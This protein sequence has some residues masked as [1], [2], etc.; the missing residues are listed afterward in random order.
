VGSI[1]SALGSMIGLTY[2]TL[3][4]SMGCIV[5]SSPVLA[6]FRPSDSSCTWGER[7]GIVRLCE[8][9]C[10][11]TCQCIQGNSL[12][13]SIPSSLGS[14]TGMTALTLNVSM[15]CSVWLVCSYVG[16]IVVLRVQLLVCYA[17]IL[18]SVIL[19]LNLFMHTG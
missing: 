17:L 12:T 16:Y 11:C 15:G 1:P 9:T 3:S 4:V 6:L 19:L 2:L 14:L 5:N 10:T 18:P 13:G 7:S 8:V